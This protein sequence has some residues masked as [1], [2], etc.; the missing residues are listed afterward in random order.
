MKKILIIILPILLTLNSKA[1]EKESI[2][3]NMTLNGYVK[4]MNTAMFND[5]D[6]IWLVDNLIHNRLNYRWYMNDQLTLAIEVRNRLIYGDLSE[7][8]PG[9]ASTLEEDNGYFKFFTKNIIESKSFVLNTSFDR[10]Y[11]EYN[12]NKW[13]ITLGRQRIN[14]GQSFAW[15]PNDIFNSYSFFDFDYEERPG[16]DALRVQ[17]YPSFTSVAD[18]AVKIDKDNNITAAGLYRFNKWSYDI[19]IMGGIIDSSDYVI[20]TGWSGSI[21]DF[22]FNGE[23]SYFH[24][25]ENFSDSTGIML[26][27]A[28]LSYMFDKSLNVS[29]EGIYNGYFD[30]LNINSFNDLYFMPLSVKT[31]SYSKFSWFGQLSYP[32]HPLITGNVAVMYF[33]SLGNGYFLMPSL[34]YSA[35]DNFEIALYGQRFEGKFGGQYDKMTMLFLRFRYSF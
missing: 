2:F 15:N 24:P 32:I 19:Q 18:I 27:S 26:V 14:W 31:T 22:A 23:I 33:P 8:I 9:Y 34:R 25:Q 4:Y 35:S 17:Y 7:V 16:S 11:L 28:G 12:M 10:A 5:V 30:K 3:S 6:S 13:V 29:I 21:K 1:Q 20:G